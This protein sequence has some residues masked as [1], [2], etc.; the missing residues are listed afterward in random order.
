MKLTKSGTIDKRTREGKALFDPRNI[1]RGQIIL[2]IAA[3][4]IIA[5]LYFRGEG[6]VRE[7]FDGLSTW[8]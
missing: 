3:I 8:P 7:F 2:A 4:A 5:W 1:R 6:G